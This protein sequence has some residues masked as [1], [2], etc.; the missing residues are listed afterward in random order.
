[1]TSL[2]ALAYFLPRDGLD[3]AGMSESREA[4]TAYARAIRLRPDYAEA[5]NNRGNVL[6]N[7][8]QFEEA[9]ADYDRAI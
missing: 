6:C 2:Q 7:L 8:G 5:Y 4:L 3:E 1:M 9:V